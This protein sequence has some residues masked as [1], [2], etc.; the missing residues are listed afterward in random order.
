MVVVVAAAAMLA[1]IAGDVGTAAAAVLAAAVVVRW[2][3][4]VVRAV[5][6]G[7]PSSLPGLA[8]VAPVVATA[9]TMP[10]VACVVRAA[11]EEFVLIVAFVAFV[12]GVPGSTPSW[13]IVVV[14]AKVAVVLM[15]V[16]VDDTAEVLGVGH[17]P[18]DCGHFATISAE[19]QQPRLNFSAG[20]TKSAHV[21]GAPCCTRMVDACTV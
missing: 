20:F 2:R 15:I 13:A 7:P 14:T 9:A 5:G 8:R 4:V 17:F 19:F 3:P 10:R 6:R 1:V 21:T 16:V 11:C 18:Q 12:A